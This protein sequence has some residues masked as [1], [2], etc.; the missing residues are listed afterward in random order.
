MQAGTEVAS[1]RDGRAERGERTRG[2]VV[3]AMLDLIEEGDLQPTAPRIAERAG[4]ALRTV[5]HHFEDLEAL[6]AEAAQRQMQRHLADVPLV[7]R[8]A[9]LDQRLEMFV[10]SRSATHEAISPVRRSAL[11]SEPFSRV[12]AG[13]LS[14]I[15][16]RGRREVERVFAKELQIRSPAA[17]R[18][19]VEAL[20][21]AASWSTWEALRAHQGLT[22]T[23]A[24]RVMKRMLSALLEQE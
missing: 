17:R 23:R 22:R 7:P 14:W 11:L 10:A 16:A 20:T 19:L 5:F 13:H 15:R 1:L 8:E 2:A 24:R 12:I 21:A 6:F 4:V 9:P 18:D 3:N